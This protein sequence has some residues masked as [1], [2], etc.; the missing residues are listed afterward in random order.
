MSTNIKEMKKSFCC[1]ELEHKSHFVCDL[2]EEKDIYL[3]LEEF[4]LNSI[5]SVNENRH[6][7]KI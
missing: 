6:Y 2:K 4:D 1:F 7:R 3:R 5:P